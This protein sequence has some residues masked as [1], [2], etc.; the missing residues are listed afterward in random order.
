MVLIMP[1]ANSLILTQ[2]KLESLKNSSDKNYVNGQKQDTSS[3]RTHNLLAF[4]KENPH[5]CQ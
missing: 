2:V 3:G 5:I 4:I 1:Q